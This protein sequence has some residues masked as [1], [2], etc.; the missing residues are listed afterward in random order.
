MDVIAFRDVLRSH[1]GVAVAYEELKPVLASRSA[2]NATYQFG[3]PASVEAVLRAAAGVAPLRLPG[4]PAWECREVATIAR[5]PVLSVA[6][7]E[8]ADPTRGD[9]VHHLGQAVSNETQRA[10]ESEQHRGHG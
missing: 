7:V 3:K 9:D 6:K 2:G 5:D 10:R 4:P 1:Q 8:C